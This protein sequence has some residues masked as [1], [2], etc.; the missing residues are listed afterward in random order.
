MYLGDGKDY[1]LLSLLLLF[2]VAFRKSLQTVM[3]LNGWP[4]KLKCFK[5]GLGASLSLFLNVRESDLLV[6]FLFRQCIAFCIRCFGNFPSEFK[7]W[8][9]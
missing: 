5:T 8:M 3:L 2:F 6:F 4:G 7:G 9:K 1:Q